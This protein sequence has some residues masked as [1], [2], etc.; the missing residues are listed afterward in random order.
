MGRKAREKHIRV[1]EP[2]VVVASE[3]TPPAPSEWSW[4]EWTIVA[5]LVAIT[6][7]VFGQIV[8]HAFLNFDDGQFIYENQHV[9][10]GDIAWALTSAE[11]GWYPLTWLSHMLDVAVWGQRAGMHLLTGLLLHAISTVLL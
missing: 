5:F 6:L 10:H 1:A 8:T 2:R 3:A 11:I 4:R 7:A 9:L